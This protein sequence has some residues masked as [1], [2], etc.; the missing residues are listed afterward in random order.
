M[1]GL[2]PESHGIVANRFYDPALKKEF[3]HYDASAKNNSR[4][5]LGEPVRN[6]E[7]TD[8]DHEILMV[9]DRFGV[10]CSDKANEQASICGQGQA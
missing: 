8:E 10:P 2:Y 7:S 6:N 3:V 1:T 4:W 5:W 9:S